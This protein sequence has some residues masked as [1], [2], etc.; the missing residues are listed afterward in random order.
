M[1]IF[2]S[3]EDSAKN[4][5]PL[6]RLQERTGAF[7][8]MVHMI[9]NR[10][11]GESWIFEK[12]QARLCKLVSLFSPLANELIINFED[13]QEEGIDKMISG[14]RTHEDNQGMEGISDDYP[15]PVVPSQEM[16]LTVDE[17]WQW[18]EDHELVWQNNVW[19]RKQRRIQGLFASLNRLSASLLAA[20]SVSERQIAVLQN[21]RDLFFTSCRTKIK[22]YEKGYPLRENPFYK[23]IAPIPI[24]SE[25][26]EQ[27][28][29][30]TLNTIDDVVREKKSFIKKAQELVENTDIQ[31]KIV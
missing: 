3:K 8:T 10:M 13:D 19:K 25:N 28:W 29:P 4:Q 5:V 18:G 30:N 20:I 31:R 1:A 14:A 2:R 21:L 15:Q 26:C 22:D 23:N 24:L 6:H 12:L 27:I 16:R 9:A 17:K 7:R 11:D